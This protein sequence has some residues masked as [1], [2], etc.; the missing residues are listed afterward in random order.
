MKKEYKWREIRY[1]H[2]TQLKCIK[3]VN[4]LCASEA[5]VS[6][7]LTTS[8]APNTTTIKPYSSMKSRLYGLNNSITLWVVH[9][10]EAIKTILQAMKQY[11]G[12]QRSPYAQF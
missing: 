10:R 5:R 4:T 12:Q 11:F 9:W 2:M 6:L 1:S 3:S 7:K 8:G